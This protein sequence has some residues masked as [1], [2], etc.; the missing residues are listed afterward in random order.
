MSGQNNSSETPALPGGITLAEL[1]ALTDGNSA[2]GVTPPRKKRPDSRFRCQFR[3]HLD[4]NKAAEYALGMELKRLKEMRQYLPTIRNALRLFL[5]LKAGNTTVLLE[6]FPSLQIHFRPDADKLL[7]EFKQILAE[8]VKKGSGDG[9]NG[10][11]DDRLERLEQIVLAQSNTSGLVMAGQGAPKPLSTG[12]LTFSPPPEDDDDGLVIRKD[13][14]AGDMSNLVASMMK[15]M[16]NGLTGTN[17][18]A[19]QNRSAITRRE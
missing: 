14:S 10:G 2:A 6:L 17:H 1:E 11:Q 19:G 9:G 8:T 15:L 4:A 3:F 16:E 18:T 13:E 12:T 7:E 5:D